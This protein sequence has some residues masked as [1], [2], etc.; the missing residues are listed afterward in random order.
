M[1]Q[2]EFCV[3][4]QKIHILMGSLGHLQAHI[5]NCNE[6]IRADKTL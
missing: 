6:K 4:G 1:F 3:N 5:K 2:F